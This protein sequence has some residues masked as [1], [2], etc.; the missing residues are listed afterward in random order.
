MA[1][2]R[3][4]STEGQR[5]ATTHRAR[6]ARIGRTASRQL[7]LVTHDQLHHLGLSDGGIRYRAGA[8]R[9]HPVHPR[10]YAL[11]PP[12]FSRNQRWLA[13]VLAC[14]PASALPDLPAAAL[15]GLVE[16]PQRFVHVSN[17]TGRGRGLPGVIVHRRRIDP[18][19]MTRIGG[20][21][22]T[23]ATRTVVDCAASL[24]VLALEELLLT[25]DSKRALDRRRLGEL[26]AQ[27]RGQRGT[28]KLRELITDDP[29][30]TR[31]LNESR[32][33]SVCRSAGIALPLCNH[34]VE[35]GN[36]TFY[37]DFC[38]PDLGLIIEA[39]SWRWHGGRHATESDADRDQLLSIAGWQVVHFTRAQILARRECRR[40]VA[41]L[42][43]TASRRRASDR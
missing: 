18:R 28:R 10:V 42:T 21:P 38:W 30:A 13:A 35:A 37:A 2:D 34:R 19:D 3:Q 11:H 23:T 1:R 27:R 5:S 12:P 41:A 4:E 40:R 24:D 8:G 25:A 43:A 33:F 31:S 6:E 22:C 26:L 39:D 32:M 36:R 20:V 9:L 16:E 15:A 7:Q 29:V 17:L 14:G